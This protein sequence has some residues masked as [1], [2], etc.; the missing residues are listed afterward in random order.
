MVFDCLVCFSLEKITIPEQDC[1]YFI[2]IEHEQIIHKQEFPSENHMIAYLKDPFNNSNDEVFD[3]TIFKKTSRKL[4]I[5]AKGRITLSHK[6]V[7]QE[8]TFYFDKI[9][10]LN[11]SERKKGKL[12]LKAVI[13]DAPQQNNI[14]SAENK[15]LEDFNYNQAKIK[16]FNVLSDP[17]SIKNFTK[18]LEKE[19]ETNVKGIVIS[20]KNNISELKEEDVLPDKYDDSFMNDLS[21]CSI[22]YDSDNEGFNDCSNSLNLNINNK[23]V[24]SENELEKKKL[25]ILDNILINPRTKIDIDLEKR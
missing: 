11:C 17:Y 24:A 1:K 25:K 4:Y 19:I 13:L 15:F 10:Q 23:G 18:N 21:F 20:K 3:I 22:S 16:F 2:E 7:I 9:V 12:L 8:Q 5:I 14:I 6:Q